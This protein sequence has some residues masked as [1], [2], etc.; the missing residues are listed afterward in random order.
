MPVFNEESTAG[1][2]ICSLYPLCDLL[3]VV[4]DGSID[5]TGEILQDLEKEIPNMTLI[6]SRTNRGKSHALKLAFTRILELRAEDELGDRDLVI[7]T[8]GDGQLP[9]EAID[10]ACRQLEKCG[11]DLLIGCRDLSLYPFMKKAGNLFLS[12]L[13][14]MLT[15]FSF[16]DTQCGF[17]VMSVAALNR[18]MPYYRARGY[19]CEQEISIISALTGLKMDNS[20]RINPCYYRSNS[21]YPDAFHITLDSFA[22]FLRVRFNTGRKMQSSSGEKSPAGDIPTTGRENN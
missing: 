12:Y 15:G 8:D 2:M 19:A 10:D 5:R 21:T 11:L 7:T 20:L 16:R 1:V 13:A 17:R 6:T 22:T 3:L 14:S 4:N 18:I 9:V